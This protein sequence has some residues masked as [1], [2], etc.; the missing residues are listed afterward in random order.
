MLK[1]R[2]GTEN[3]VRQKF[4]SDKVYDILEDRRENANEYIK[5]STTRER[6][7]VCGSNEYHMKA[8]GLLDA[9]CVLL[10]DNRKYIEKRGG[11]KFYYFL[12]YQ[13]D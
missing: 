1:F 6:A 8:S 4:L 5:L 3:F 13:R 10:Y 2:V 12:L 7:I 9:L 11:E